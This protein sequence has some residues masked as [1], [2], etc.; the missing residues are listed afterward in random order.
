MFL[1]FAGFGL[2][3][4]AFIAPLPALYVA[5]PSLG[6]HGGFERPRDWRAMWRYWFF[7]FVSYIGGF[8]WI[9]YTIRVFGGFHWVLSI[10]F[11]SIF[12]ADQGLQFAIFLFLFAKARMNGWPASLA[13]ASSFLGIEAIFPMLFEHYYGNSLVHVPLLIQIADIGGP[14]MCTLLVIGTASTLYEMIASRIKKASFPIRSTTAFSLYWLF[15]LAY[16]IFRMNLEPQKEANAP[17]IEVGVI[18]A[19]LGLFDRFEHPLDGILKHLKMTE[20]LLK[21]N[22]NRID[23]IVWPESAFP[24]FIQD[25][26]TFR[27]IIPP[28]KSALLFGG[29][30]K[31]KNN[32]LYNTAFLFDPSRSLLD[33]YDKNHL[34]AFGEYIPLGDVFP[35]L[36]ELSPH[37]GRF[38]PGHH[39]SPLTLLLPDGRAFRL[40]VLMCY[41]DILS[42]FVRQA[43]SAGRPHL[44][45]NLTVDSW[46]GN[47]HE[48]WVHLALSQFRAV[49]HRRWLVRST[50]TGVSA[51]IDS[52]GVVRRH[53]NV[54]KE[55]TLSMRVPLREEHTLFELI[56]PWPG[57]IGLFLSLF[58]AFKPRRTLAPPF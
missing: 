18:Q 20:E 5:D 9:E 21:K 40:T 54:F 44:L 6:N 33:S 43:V 16:G 7:G 52:R 58:F 56:G 1:G 48:P 22:K 55:A 11:S 27:Q 37:S 24:F 57:W 15:A 42:G 10:L 8:Y 49:E 14:G 2:W 31:D 12:W 28:I 36:Y 45:V 53:G 4:I 19:N 39:F 13:G 46:F 26:K 38:T 35:S 32:W 34:L 50:I 47:T 30:R 17:A 29:I 3:P 41:E 23:L 51:F 25:E